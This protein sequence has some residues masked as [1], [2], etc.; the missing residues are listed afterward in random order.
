VPVRNWARCKAASVC[1]ADG[2]LRGHDVI[3]LKRHG[4]ACP[5]HP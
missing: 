2:R 4:R 1:R 5:G 3:L